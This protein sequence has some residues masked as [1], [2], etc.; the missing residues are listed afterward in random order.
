MRLLVFLVFIAISLGGYAQNN[1]VNIRVVK[2]SSGQVL[3]AEVWQGLMLKGHYKLKAENPGKADTEY[4]IV[5]LT[6]EEYKARMEALPKP[7]PSSAFTNGKKLKGF[8]AV[9][10]E[11]D[12]INLFN[13]KE[14]IIVLNF[15]FI[16]CRPCRLEMPELNNL[17]DSFK[18]EDII[19]AAI[20]LDQE[21]AI[22]KFLE[23]NPFKYKIIPDGRTIASNLGIKS[24]PTHAIIDKEGKVY[25]H[26]SGLASNTIYWVEK[27]IK[28]LL[29]SE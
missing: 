20:G 15:W 14:K 22:K 28:E 18:N 12:L 21:D 13:A 24:Y 25:F 11:G 19:F 29:D 5:R 10:I 4:F 17:V 23:T 9:D 2:D 7:K 3:P 1:K 27:S 26:T 8:K 6:E 16:N